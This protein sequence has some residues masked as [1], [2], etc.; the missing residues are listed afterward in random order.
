MCPSAA[1]I[2]ETNKELDSIY[3]REVTSAFDFHECSN[4]CLSS[5][6]TK[7]FM[8]RAFTFDDVGRTCILYDEDP[9]FYGEIGQDSRTMNPGHRRP[10][11]SSTG[12]L[13]RILC[14]NMDRGE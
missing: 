13:Y 1:F 10:M 5:L 3:E 9:I 11:K 12:N 6:E 7:G 14:V 4:Y 2:L 8:C